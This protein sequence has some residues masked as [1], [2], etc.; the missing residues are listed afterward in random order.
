MSILSDNLESKIQHQTFGFFPAPVTQY[1]V[2]NHEEIKTLILKWMEQQDIK[3][4]TGRETIC[5]NVAQF[6]E[7]NTALNDIPELNKVITEA[8]DYHN[9]NAFN[10]ETDLA[11]NDS[12]IEIATQGAIYAPHEHSNCLYSLT[13]FINFD[14]SIHSSVKFRKLTNS[15][16]FP[17]LQLPVKEYTAFNLTEATFTQEEGDI[18]I[19]PANLT[20]GYDS[21]PNPERIT[22]TANIVPQ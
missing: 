8:V 11:V 4:K 12:Y 5:H 14:N 22:F 16:H 2:D 17:I 7:N 20:H 19:Y 21:N 10:Y 18:I 13:Y 9:K 3:E 6:G 15:P 1:K